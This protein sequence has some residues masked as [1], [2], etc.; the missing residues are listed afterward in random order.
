MDF[1]LSEDL[2]VLRDSANR[3]L[4]KEV[5][6]R[7]LLTPGATTVAMADYNRLWPSVVDLGW[8]G[9][10]IPEGYG[11]LGMSVLDLVMIVGECGRFLAPLP[12]F[13]ALAGAWAIEAF[14][15][16]VQKALWLPEIADGSM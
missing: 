1:S 12:L 14:G 3:F 2:L 8:S 4:G 16:E 6:L 15:S 13:G 10:V 7:P 11:G 5:D 9:M